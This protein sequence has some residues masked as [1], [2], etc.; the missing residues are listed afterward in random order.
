MLQLEILFFCL[1]T[2]TFFCDQ[3]KIH[4]KKAFLLFA[5][6]VGTTIS[7][8]AQ[9]PSGFQFGAGLRLG[10]AVGDFSNTS[11]MSIGG[12]LQ[13]EYGFSEKASGIISAGYNHFLG[14]SV[15]ESGISIVYPN[16]S[17]IPVLVGARYYATPKIFI[18]AQ[19]GIGIFTAYSESVTGFNWQPQI[20][21]NTNKIQIALNYNGLSKDGITTSHLGLTG[22][23]KFGGNN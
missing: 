12:E 18:G 14:K 20:G 4:M 2:F 5:I 10:L 9:A 8:N 16:T 15:T 23:Y 1:G 3:I 19:V 6:V 13:G 22:I 11:T 21:F 7:V 17:L